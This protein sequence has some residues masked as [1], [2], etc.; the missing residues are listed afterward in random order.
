MCVF[1]SRWRTGATACLCPQVFTD[2]AT[3][4]SYLV[5]DTAHQCD[6]I[7]PFAPDGRSIGPL[8]SHTGPTTEPGVCL[9]P[10]GGP[11]SGTSSHPPW[12]CEGVS[13]FRDPVDQR[14][15]LFGSHLSGWQANGAM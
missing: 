4:A 1:H 2:P 9:K 10:Y 13:M 8:C 11:G 7:S 14:L 15:F 3:N 12:V 5:R 6:S